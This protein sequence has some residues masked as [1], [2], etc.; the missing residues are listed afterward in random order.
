MSMESFRARSN[1][2]ARKVGPGS[3]RGANAELEPA[4]A[5]FRIEELVPVISVL[6]YVPLSWT[7]KPLSHNECWNAASNPVTTA[8]CPFVGAVMVNWAGDPLAGSSKGL[9]DEFF[10]VPVD[11][12]RTMKLLTS[13]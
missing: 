7:P 3:E 5:I 4:P 12:F 9:P 6:R 11:W 2:H 13:L 1:P 10:T 8:V